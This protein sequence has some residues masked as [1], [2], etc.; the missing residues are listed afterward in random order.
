MTLHQNFLAIFS[1][2]NIKDIPNIIVNNA[3][4]YIFLHKFIR[5]NYYILKID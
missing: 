2:L 5:I 4:M 3:I 1:L